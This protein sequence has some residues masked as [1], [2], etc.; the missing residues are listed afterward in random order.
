MNT[1]VNPVLRGFNPD[2]S[3]VRAGDDYYI[4][5]STFEWFPGVQ[6]HHSRD[7]VHWRL[8]KR[9]LDRI[10]QLNM[11]GNGDSDGVWAPCLTYDDGLFYLIY[12]DVKSHKG[13]FKDT[14]NYLV[15]AADIE[16]PWSEPVYLN[17]SGFDPSLF[18]DDDGRKWLLNMRWDFRKEKNKFGG[19]VIQ[20]YSQTEGRLI[21]PVTT[22]FE[23]TGIGFTEGPHLYKQ[24]GY[25]Y[26]ITAEGG[27]RYKHAVTVARAA[28]LMGPYEI[29]PLNPMLT[30]SGNPALLLQKAGHASLV[31]TRTGEWYMAHLCAR[32]V[33]G[34]HCTLGRETALQ[35][36]YWDAEG[37]LRLEGGG[38]APSAAVQAPQLPPHPFEPEP[39]RDDFDGPLLGNQW[40]T[41]R[42][43]P[44]PDWL[45]LSERQG[46]LRLKGRESLSS[47]HRQSLV[48]RR[49]QVFNIEAETVIEFEPENFQQLAGLILY[50]NTEDYVYLRI[51]HLEQQ[52]RVIGIIQSVHGMYDELLAADLQIPD[53]GPVRLKAVVNRDR[54]QFY[55]AIEDSSWCPVGEE[56]HI[57]HLSDEAKEPLRFTGTF[58]GICA[59]D[60]SGTR[61]HADFDYFIYR[62]MEWI[63]A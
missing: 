5:T 44:D 56:S 35:K 55:Y 16:G 6:I 29:D 23:G 42:I 26:L 60:L 19:I 28:L 4:A 15:T 53:S 22:I 38:N 51:T 40:N 50:Y 49:Q 57:L 17:S 25:Y 30:S 47:C 61:K 12:T 52:G 59:Q 54:L 39:E 58:V 2:P 41:L 34:F 32:P 8:L 33:D 3:I 13:A 9:P 1:I 27:T 20:E 37:W 21:G 11:Q 18:H 48:A 7:L 62:E 43:P 14:H 36:C 10:S 45:S 63:E 46:F 24:N 31:E